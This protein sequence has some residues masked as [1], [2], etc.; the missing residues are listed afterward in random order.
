MLS[1]L[2][3]MTPELAA[4]IVDWRDTNEE[5]SDGGAEEET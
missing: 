5:V 3:R 2:P 4:A 1:L